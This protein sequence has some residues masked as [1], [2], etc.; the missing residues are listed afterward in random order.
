LRKQ[1][2]KNEIDGTCVTYGGDEMF[3]GETRR[4]ETT[5]NTNR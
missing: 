3:G 5:W 4:R 1:I 2:E